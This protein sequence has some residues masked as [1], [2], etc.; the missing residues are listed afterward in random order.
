MYS[1]PA[2]LLCQR[3]VPM[4]ETC[5]SVNPRYIVIYHTVLTQLYSQTHCELSLP[6]HVLLV[7]TNGRRSLVKGWINLHFN[8]CNE[9][10]KFLLGPPSTL[11]QRNWKSS[12]FK[13]FSTGKRKTGIFKFLQFEE[14]FRKAPFSWRIRV[15]GRP[16]RTNK[17]AFSNSAGVVWTLRNIT[18]RLFQLHLKNCLVSISAG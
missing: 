7:A 8:C 14:R 10:D 5:H 3:I 9:T 2:C 4:R 13:M 6:S 18:M 15:D 11:P 12:V 1:N 16:T 17:A